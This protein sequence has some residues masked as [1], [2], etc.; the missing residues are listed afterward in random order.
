M[1]C[2][3]LQGSIYLIKTFSNN[4]FKIPSPVQTCVFAKINDI[5]AA[6]MQKVNQVNLVCH[7]SD[8][9]TGLKI[10]S[11]EI[12]VLC[13]WR[14][15]S[16]QCCHNQLLVFNNNIMTNIFRFGSILWIIMRAESQ[17]S[18]QEEDWPGPT[19]LCTRACPS[20]RQYFIALL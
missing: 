6:G 16:A 13:R 20:H 8:H 4:V 3:G 19:Q 5:W 7:C 10:S 12:K 14:F 1:L 17:P 2:Q 18:E 9:K 15:S 11:Y